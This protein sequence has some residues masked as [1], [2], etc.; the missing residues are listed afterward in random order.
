MNLNFQLLNVNKYLNVITQ[1]QDGSI[2]VK[3][4]ILIKFINIKMVVLYLMN[5]Y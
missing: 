1:Q 4:V 5:V 2:H 3:I